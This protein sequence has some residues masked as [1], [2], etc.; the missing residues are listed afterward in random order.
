MAAFA[1]LVAC[2]PIPKPPFDVTHLTPDKVL[3]V[4]EWLGSLDLSEPDPVMQGLHLTPEFKSYTANRNGQ[5]IPNIVQVYSGPMRNG[6][7]TTLN[8]AIYDPHGVAADQRDGG[9][10]R[11]VL[12]WR[13]R[14]QGEF[15]SVE[16][17]VRVQ[18]LRNRF[19]SPVDRFV[20]TD[21]GG[22]GFVFRVSSLGGWR[23][24]TA[25]YEDPDG[26]IDTLPVRQK[27]R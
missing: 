3:D 16:T 21:G 1:W 5:E 15:H 12:Q 7:K 26:C 24:Y 8:Y 19:G 17:C 27:N 13:L 11:A 25:G 2:A 22:I 20:I 14:P 18:D 23:T 4:V 9:M 6:S 10:T